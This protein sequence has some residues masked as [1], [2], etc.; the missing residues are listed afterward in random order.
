MNVYEI[1]PI[2]LVFYTRKYKDVMKVLTEPVN[3]LGLSS[4][5]T[6][7]GNFIEY[8]KNNLLFLSRYHFSQLISYNK[9]THSTSRNAFSYDNAQKYKDPNHSSV[10]IVIVIYR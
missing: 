4:T 2:L 7:E 5:V 6:D 9:Q 1:L 10:R 8:I 3:Y